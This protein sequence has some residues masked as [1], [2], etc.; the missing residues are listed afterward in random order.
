M[1]SEPFQF[2]TMTM[3][4]ASRAAAGVTLCRSARSTSSELSTANVLDAAFA[5][6]T[7]IDAGIPANESC[8]T[9][10]PASLQTTTRELIANIS[11]QLATLD[12]QRRQLLHLL[13]NV[14]TSATV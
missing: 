4:Q 2:G 12:K 5:D 8:A 7:R 1:Q 3:A 14:E 6:Y 10:S 9:H 13:E 11:T